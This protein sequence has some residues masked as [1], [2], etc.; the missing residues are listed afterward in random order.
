MKRHTAPSQFTMSSSVASSE[1]PS[2]TQKVVHDTGYTA[3]QVRC[4]CAAA[5]THGA[6]FRGKAQVL[7]TVFAGLTFGFALHKGD[8]YRVGVIRDQMRFTNFTMLKVRPSSHVPQPVYAS[9]AK[10][11]LL[12]VPYVASQ[13]F[14]TAASF[15]TLSVT[16]MYGMKATHAKIKLIGDFVVCSA[17]T[18]AD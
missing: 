13:M 6:H 12:H 3:I 2:M 11:Y 14:L 1:T 16:A 4:D 9:H 15:S 8:V 10:F 7:A 17:S 5:S 18:S